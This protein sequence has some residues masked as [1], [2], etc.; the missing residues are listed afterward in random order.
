MT[1]ELFPIVE[2]EDEAVVINAVAHIEALKKLQIE[3]RLM[4]QE[5][6]ELYNNG[7]W[8][9]A[10][11]IKKQIT[12]L[13]EKIIHEADGPDILGGPLYV[14]DKRLYKL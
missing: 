5:Y 13:R 8:A 12:K 9:K 3:L 1:N 2:T 4:E 11:K 6:T 7:K 10:A 14:V